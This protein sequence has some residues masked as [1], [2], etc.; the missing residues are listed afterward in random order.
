MDLIDATSDLNL[1]D[2]QVQALQTLSEFIKARRGGPG[3]AALIRMPTGTGK[4]GVISVAAQL[5]VEGDVLILTP[6]DV[7]VK[8]MSRDVKERFWKQIGAPVPSSKVIQRIY[9]SKAAES[10]SRL[11]VPTIWTATITTLQMI[12]TQY[13]EV[14]RELATRLRL[15]VVDEGHYEPAVRWA[16]AVRQLQR[17]TILFT[18]TPYRNDWRFFEVDED[19]TYSYSHLEAEKDR[20]IRKLRFETQ[21]FDDEVSFCSGLIEAWERLK[22]PR[23]IV[24]CQ[25]KNSVQA[26]TQE[27]LNQNVSAIGVHERFDRAEGE[28]FRR[29]VPRP[30]EEPA[31]FWVHQFKLIEGIDDARFRLVAFYEPFSTERAFVQQIG[32]VLRN[33]GQKARQ[34]ACVFCD[35]RRHLERSWVA[36]RQY[37]E[38]GAEG[39]FLS[40][41]DFA[42]QQP[43]IQYVEGRFREQLDIQSTE[44]FQDFNYPR[45]TKVFLVPDDFD[46]DDLA[47][48][49]DDQWSQNDFDL[50]SVIRPDAVT[51]I[52]PYI[53][54]RN[55]PV[56]LR[57]TFAEYEVGFTIY[58]LI[59]NHLFFYDTQGK[60]PMELSMFPRVDV[61][62]LQRL[63]Q[64]GQSRVTSVSLINTDLSRYTARR[65][66]LEAHAIDELGPDLGDH[67]QFVSTARGVTPGPTWGAVPTVQ[68]YVGFTRGRVSDKVRESTPYDE[69]VRWLDD[70]AIA[71][72]DES[73]VPSSIFE[74][75]A[76]VV[77][78]PSDPSPES[79][80]L[81]FDLE[82]FETLTAGGWEALQIDDLCLPVEHGAFQC[83]VNDQ[84][85]QVKLSWQSGTGTYRLDS[86]SLDNAVSMKSSL[87][88]SQAE[89]LVGF[90]N[91]EQLFRIVPKSAA[92][93]YCIYARGHFY[94]PRPAL[95]GRASSDRLDLLQ[96]LHPINELRSISTEKGAAGSATGDGWADDSLFCLI[97][98]LGQGT[99]LEPYFGSI[100]LLICDDMGREIADFIALDEVNRKVMAIHAKAFPT[101][102]RLSASALHD[103][104]SQAIKNLAWL[105]P[106][107]VSRSADF[108]RWDTQWR[109]RPQGTV[110]SRIR[111]GGA[112]TGV[113]AWNRIHGVLLDPQATREVWI[114]LGSGTSKDEFNRQRQAA[115][116]PAHVIQLLYSLQATWSAVQSVG[117][118]LHVF[119]SP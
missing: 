9:P 5:L 101:E 57:K 115:S 89:S 80:L 96:I 61:R 102:R 28:M 106:Y 13:P 65:R 30:D 47:E 26:V 39:K 119:C 50:Q 24:R 37:D 54:L 82:E 19:F 43:R 23:V 33:P 73:L 88:A 15:L 32:R 68:R 72:R 91:R 110:R 58:R 14:Y 41:K 118:K 114:V 117:V 16:K 76:D 71:L 4:T 75:Y 2:H 108:R 93:D 103:V 94:Q 112:I 6:W 116:P 3:R 52:H 51:R 21:E 83:T 55:S 31:V 70:L 40:P 84:S 12:H 107:Q 85:H 27:L 86:P 25:T 74:R 109:S 49:V 53:A 38:S 62:A 111:R 104:T 77:E 78:I 66:V 113:A 36:Y 59:N 48:S 99:E 22:K 45:S 95:W 98:R 10:I 60:S 97:D 1:W 92:E 63:Y 69:Y 81:D 44:V 87:G 11:G 64:G 105:Q 18:A 42:S 56:L 29:V 34:Y 79:I 20:V 7:L 46:L 35:P 17:P 8:Q 67:T 100:D 90:L